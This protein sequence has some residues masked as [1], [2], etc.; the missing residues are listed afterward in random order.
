MEKLVESAGQSELMHVLSASSAAI[1]ER[2]YKALAPAA[3]SS[4]GAGRLRQCLAQLAEQS[5][6]LLR[7]EAIDRG[8]ARA[9]GA[10]LARLNA[11]QIEPVG[12]LQEGLADQLAQDLPPGL[13]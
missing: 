5:T 9:I 2:W 10:S 11:L 7:D 13:V 4:R 12:R 6:N 3:H 8:D 1:A